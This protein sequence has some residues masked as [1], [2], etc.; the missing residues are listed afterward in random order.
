MWFQSPEYLC[1]SRLQLLTPENRSNILTHINVLAHQKVLDVGCGTGEF[2]RYISK[3]QPGT[4]IGIDIEPTFIEVA[5]RTQDENVIYMQA[6]ALNLPFA[7]DFFDV[8]VS[9]TFFTC[10]FDPV[11]AM[12]EMQRVCKPGG[13]IISITA[14]SFTRIPFFQ[15]VYADYDWVA[16][17]HALKNKLDQL[18]FEESKKCVKGLIPEVIPHFF[19]RQGLRQVTIFPISKFFSLSN[20]TITPEQRR[21]Y[22]EA[23]YQAECSR[24]MLLGNDASRYIHLLKIRKA[25]LM[26]PENQ[27]WQWNG[28]NNLLITGINP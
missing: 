18:F 25:A 5:Q 23:E 19:A 22:L 10:I 16:E 1:W 20:A 13:K 14:E 17:Y 6:D 7:D 9:H 21:N 26:I 3:N 2:T 12:Q 27:V 28:G 11:K 8:V 24:A 15:G 4:Y